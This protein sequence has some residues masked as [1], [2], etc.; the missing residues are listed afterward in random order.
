MWAIRYSDEVKFY[1][2]DNGD[3]VFDLLVKIEELRYIPEGIPPEG[4]TPLDPNFYA[5]EVLRHVVIYEQQDGVLVIQV[6]KPKA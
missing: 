2:L 1:F 4:C 6:V 5:W 3:L